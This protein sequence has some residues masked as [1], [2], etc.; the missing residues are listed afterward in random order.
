[1]TDLMAL[2]LALIATIVG[3]QL[4]VILYYLTRDVM[5]RQF[6]EEE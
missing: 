6:P 5:S 1:M 4:G 2:L 3:A